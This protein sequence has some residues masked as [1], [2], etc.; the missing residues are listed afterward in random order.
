MRALSPK[1]RARLSS[2]PSWCKQ[3]LRTALAPKAKRSACTSL[4][5]ARS[6]ALSA[7]LGERPVFYSRL[8]ALKGDTVLGWGRKWSG[9]RA[10]ALAAQHGREFRLVEDGFLRS[11]GRYDPGLSLVLDSTGIYYDASMPSDL[12]HLAKEGLS[13]AE[14]VRSRALM[15]VWRSERLSKY[16]V[17][18]DVS[19]A[20]PSRYVLLCDQTFGDA[21][22][23]FGCADDESFSRMLDAAL[24]EYPEHD[25]ILKTHPDVVTNRKRGH[26]DIATIS[27]NNRVRIISDPV[28]PSRLIEHA[29]AVYTV[30]SQMGFEALVWGKRVRCFGMPFYAGWGLTDDELPAPDRRKKVTLEQLV[31]GALVKYPR[32]IDPVIMQRCEPER[33]FSYVGLQRRK[34]LEFPQQIKAFGFSRWKR[35][36]IKAFLQGSEVLFDKHSQVGGP[37]GASEAIA[38]WGS[39]EVPETSECATVLRIEDGFLR[40]SGLGADL[41]RP[42]SL[43]I[44]DIGIYYD[45]SRPSRLERILET[46]D[47]DH[48]A[49]GRARALRDKIIKLDV[50]KYNL[51]KQ[52][53]S[54]PDTEKPVL[55]VVGQVETDAS[56]RLGSPDVNS[57]IELL[58]RVRQENPSAYIVYKPHPDVVAGLRKRGKGE[59][60]CLKIA[61]EVLS[62]PVSLSILLSQIDELHTMTSLMGFEAL[63]RGVKVVCHGLPFY[64]GWGLTED[65]LSCARRKRRLSVDELVH[66]TLIG[67]PRYFNYE[68]NCFV[69]PEQA[70]DQLAYLAETGPQRRSLNRKLLRAAI[71]AWQ[72]LTG[73]TQ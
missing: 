64:A 42:L 15:A 63:I 30:T 35:P 44:D 66:G 13:E 32:Y 22:I 54:R 60:S 6:L 18:R 24:A 28:S 52:S 21:S 17:A 8:L 33:A 3:F 26:F 29:E 46:Q 53:W 1:W 38:I 61:D 68:R 57:N 67:Y 10:E 7:V 62:L 70:V 55:L 36:F 69:E 72:K 31:H 37:V 34:R 20:L 9:R 65:R 71:I 59:D 2:A 27:E 12:E 47:L 51:S 58:Q 48:T 45:A 43:V 11:I 56:I 73:S 41:V 50:T 49:I 40:S 23:T 14:I 4:M 39:A 19:G 5:M 25:V 16:N